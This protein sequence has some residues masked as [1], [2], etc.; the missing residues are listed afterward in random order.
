MNKINTPSNR[1][2]FIFMAC[3]GLAA[4]G[5]VLLLING[6]IQGEKVALEVQHKARTVH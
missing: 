4:V 1:G 6:S 3:C 5:M 2:F